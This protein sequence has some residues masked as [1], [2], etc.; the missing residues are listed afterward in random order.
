M[1]DRSKTAKLLFLTT[2]DTEIL[3][4]TRATE[5]LPEGF[6]EVRCANPTKL[7][8][9]RAFF[10]ETLPEA[11]AVMVR[12][13][14]GRRAWS[15]GFEELRRRCVE[16][17][18]PLLAFGGESEPDAELTALSTA[19]SGTVAEAFEYLRCGGVQNTANLLRFLSDTVLFEGY[20][21]EPP[22]SLPELGVYHPR[23]TDGST[24]EDLL[25]L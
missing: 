1:A 25:S 14:G 7:E 9:P 24:L 8:E 23:L 4:A 3:A 5:L 21:F 16:L 10:E 12:L 11:G 13:L 2:A 17:G 19:P 22:K 15:E 6:P 18:V 20:G